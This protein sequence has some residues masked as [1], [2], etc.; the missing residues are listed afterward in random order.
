GMPVTILNVAAEAPEK[1]AEGEE[2]TRAEADK[3]F[4]GR[5]RNAA[6]QASAKQQDV[7]KVDVIVR[8]HGATPQEAI[9]LEAERGYDLLIVG[10]TNTAA[11]RSGFH[12][13]LSRLVGKFDGSIAI[14]VARGEHA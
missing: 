14:A 6:K 8:Q 1:P 7:L 2:T 4:A 12:D 3:Q 10:I 13:D 9:A 11:S 5:V